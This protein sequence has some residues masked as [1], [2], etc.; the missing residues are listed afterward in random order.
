[1]RPFQFQ[2]VVHLIR[3]TEIRAHD[4]EGLRQGLASAS[5]DCIFYHT[6]QVALRFAD[7]EE[8]PHN[9]FVAWVDGVVQDRETAERLAFACSA[10]AGSLAALRSALLVV[11]DSIPT[12]TRETRDAPGGGDFRFHAMDSVAVPTGIEAPSV[13][14]LFQA[15]RSATPDCVFYHLIEQPLLQPENPAG[16]DAWVEAQGER[17]LAEILRQ[18]PLSWLPIEDTRRQIM[19][20]WHMS[21]IRRRVAAR[22]AQ[23]EAQRKRE[24]QRAVA[25][26]VG[27]IRGAT[28]DEEK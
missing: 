25:Q 2:N 9:D 10:E 4:L 8:L 26:L 13:E 3:P 24:G 16:I 27:R 22:S 5:A 12:K 21:Q 6:H 15:L 17:R 23:P 14:E 7:A 28:R 20:R 11:L 18:A 1:M 19:R